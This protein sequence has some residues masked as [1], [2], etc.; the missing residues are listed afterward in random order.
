MTEPRLR[1]NETAGYEP[2]QQLILALLGSFPASQD[3]WADGATRT[4]A[5]APDAH[6]SES[7]T[8]DR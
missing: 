4:P 7:G 2:L 6:R 8:D 5:Y 1:A 3:E